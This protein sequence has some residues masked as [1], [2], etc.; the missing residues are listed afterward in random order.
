MIR[1]SSAFAATD[2]GVTPFIY[3][4]P[5]SA[6]DDL[7]HRLTDPRW[8]DRET[9]SA[10]EQGPPLAAMQSLVAWWR[11]TYDWRKT[12]TELNSHPQFRTEIDGLGIHFL[13]VRS[14]H[15]NALPM[16]LTHGWPSTILLFRKVIDALVDPTA[17]G[18]TAADAFHIVIPSLPG[19]G[20]SDKPTARG[21]DANRT[22]RAW[23]VLMR[24]LGYNR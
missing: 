2:V 8:P 13:H 3:H 7:K 14:K 23:G 24:R 16:I 1:P 15:P 11:S 10:W 18:G 9:G 6:L 12:E 17:H 19:F 20:F 4:A 5:Q 21:W 22:A